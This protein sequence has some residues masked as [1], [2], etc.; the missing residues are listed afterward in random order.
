[1]NTGP[2]GKVAR[3]V[4]FELGEV[5]LSKPQQK[6]LSHEVAAWHTKVEAPAG[7]YP[8]VGRYDGSIFRVGARIEGRVIENYTPSLFGGVAYGGRDGSEEVGKPYD[9]VIGIGKHQLESPVNEERG[10]IISLDDGVAEAFEVT[11]AFW[12]YTKFHA[13]H[14]SVKDRVIDALVDVIIKER[15]LDELSLIPAPILNDDLYDRSMLHAVLNEA[16]QKQISGLYQEERAIEHLARALSADFICKMHCGKSFSDLGLMD[17]M[18]KEGLWFWDVD[19]VGHGVGR[20]SVER[21]VDQELTKAGIQER[22][23]DAVKLA[24]KTGT[25]LE[26]ADRITDRNRFQ[27]P[28]DFKDAHHVSAEVVSRGQFDQY[29]VAEGFAKAGFDVKQYETVMK[30]DRS[31]QSYSPTTLVEMGV[32]PEQ[33]REHCGKASTLNTHSIAAHIL[34]ENGIKPEKQVEQDNSIELSR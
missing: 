10:V 3:K 9:Y 22:D 18:L 14:P 24:L 33:Y 19:G 11:D 32:E 7:T 25:L 34:R 16:M 31:I 8:I 1:M 30:V 5:E 27:G 20:D 6:E 12:G 2:L 15:V 21:F 26:A 4:T 13:S 28:K 23:F 29:A 17:N